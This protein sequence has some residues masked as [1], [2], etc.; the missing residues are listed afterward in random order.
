M[1]DLV[2]KGHTDQGDNKYDV[3]DNYIYPAPK[4]TDTDTCHRAEYAD[5]NHEKAVWTGEDRPAPA[6]LLTHGWQENAISIS[7]VA[8]NTEIGEHCPSQSYPS[9]KF[10]TMD[11]LRNHS[12]PL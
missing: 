12:L 1:P 3:T 10:R 7:K 2:D 11:V 9:V 6:E 8:A 5:S 4:S